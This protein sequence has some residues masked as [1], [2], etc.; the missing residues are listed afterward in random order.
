MLRACGQGPTLKNPYTACV[1]IYVG[2]FVM[3]TTFWPH[4]YSIVGSLW[5]EPFPALYR[6]I[7]VEGRRK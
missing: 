3:S 5:M 4:S 7:R 2:I 6:E 1:Q